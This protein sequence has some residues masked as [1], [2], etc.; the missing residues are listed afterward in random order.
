MDQKQ[1]YQLILDS[2]LPPTFDQIV[3]DWYTPLSQE[4]AATKKEEPMVIG[5]QGAQ[6]SGKST[7]ASF[8]KNLLEEDFG[9]RT[10]DISL[11]DF[12][13]GHS[14]RRLLAANVHPLFA[15]RGV[16]GT[17]DINL[18]IATIQKLRS[19]K[20]GHITAIPRF[21][22]ATDDRKPAR[23]WDS[24]AGPVDVIILEGWCVG[25]TAETADALAQPKNELER[26]EDP[27][28]IWRG[29]ANDALNGSYQSLFDLMDKLIVLAAPSFECVYE[30][31]WLQEQKLVA[32]WSSENPHTSSRFLDEE[33]VKHFISHYERLTRHCLAT[34]ETRA[35]WMLTLNTR[36]DITGLTRRG[37]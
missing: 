6:G 31:R 18:A 5:I 19:Q 7:L 12:Y 1:R 14:E 37:D 27:K 36:H 17:H 2:E 16:P 29:Y 10:I 9:L 4:I 33:D 21:D 35:D 30:W 23:E 28:G 8:V 32:K 26:N 24:V 15:T 22:K 20:E 11:D 3:T 25:A 13:L 34:V